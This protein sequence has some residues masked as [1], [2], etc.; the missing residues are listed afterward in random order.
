MQD[1]GSEGKTIFLLYSNL[2][3]NS[4]EIASLL[5]TACQYQDTQYTKQGRKS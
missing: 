1:E 2:L 5:D 4:F 3:N